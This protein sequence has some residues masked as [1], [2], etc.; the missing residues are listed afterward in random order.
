LLSWHA[1]WLG[2]DVVISTLDI[3]LFVVDN[4]TRLATVDTEDLHLVFLGLVLVL[5]LHLDEA[6]SPASLRLA[7]THDDGISDN[8]KLLEVFDE[9]GFCKVKVR[10]KLTIT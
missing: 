6:K 8:S 7:I 4:V 9:I 2:L 5:E 3:D 1:T 10:S